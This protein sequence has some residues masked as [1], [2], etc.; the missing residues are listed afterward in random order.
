MDSREATELLLTLEHFRELSAADAAR[1][2]GAAA[3]EEFPRGRFVLRE[4]DAAQDLFI[5]LTGEMKACR[6]NAEGKEIILALLKPGAVLGELGLLLNTPRTG[7]VVTLSRCVVARI[8]GDRFSR[9]LEE[10][11]AFAKLL[12]TMLAE[13]VH[14]SSARLA[15]LTFL[16]VPSRLFYTLLRLAEP[17]EGDDGPELLV[18]QRPSQQELG[19]LLSASREAISRAQKELE[20]RGAIE[21]LPDQ[22]RILKTAR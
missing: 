8:A 7:D 14:Y 9:L 10:L 6:A 13:R 15:E 22:I 19:Q 3:L 12:L 17:V 18:R 2:I 16:D 11:P 4:R 20:E 5:L 21:V 1:V